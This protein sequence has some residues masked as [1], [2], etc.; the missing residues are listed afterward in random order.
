M[1]PVVRRNSQ[2]FRTTNWSKRLIMKHTG[3]V[4]GL[5]L[6]VNGANAQ[7]TNT[8]QALPTKTAPKPTLSTNAELEIKERRSRARSLLVSLSTDARTFRDQ[9]LRARSL[10]RIA[11]ALSQ[12]DSE[13]ARLLFRKAWEA[14]EVAD[15]ESDRKLQEEIQQQKSR[16]GGGYAINLPPNVRREVL[17][18]AAKHDRV[19]G[20]E[21]LEKL[22]IQ[23]LEAANSATTSNRNRGRLSEALSERLAVA[24]EL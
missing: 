23:K 16:T 10:A 18:L 14:A 19:L 1:S 2:I 8:K 17:R 4:L 7:S 9:T 6:L 15:Q 22:R 24:K 5:L 13:Q 20:E 12:V 21:F 3:L 11:D